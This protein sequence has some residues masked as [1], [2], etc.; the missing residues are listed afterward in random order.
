M[1]ILM[2]SLLFLFCEIKLSHKVYFKMTFACSYYEK[3]PS[4]MKN[5]TKFSPQ[6]FSIFTFVLK[7]KIFTKISSC[8]EIRNFQC[9]KIFKFFLALFLVKCIIFILL[10][11]KAELQSF[12]LIFREI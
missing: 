4:F 3:S 1:S 12:F 11:E 7:C 8:K 9:V 2:R 5:A 10:N 6:L